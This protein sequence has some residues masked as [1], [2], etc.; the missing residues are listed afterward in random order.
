MKTAKADLKVL[1]RDQETARRD[2]E[3]A[4]RDSEAARREVGEAL[5]EIDRS[6]AELRKAGYDPESLKATIR[7]S[8]SEI[9][10]MDIA[11]ITREAMESANPD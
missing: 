10:H 11:K 1:R 6:A 9:E 7:A 5:R 8:L 4:L 3:T 2:T